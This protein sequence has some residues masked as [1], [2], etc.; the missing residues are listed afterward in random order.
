[1]IRLARLLLASMLAL[2]GSIGMAKA[3]DPIAVAI[4]TPGICGHDAVLNRISS[5]FRYQVHH[6]PHLANVAI[7]DFHSIGESRYEPKIADQNPIERRYCHATADLSDGRS[8]DV[9]YVIERPM[10]FA[11]I[12]SNVEFCVSG[13]DRWNVYDGRCRVLRPALW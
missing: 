13:F 6:V 12:G 9:W 3:A 8:R 5:R 11:G 2:A 7:A 10:G 4:E 1:M